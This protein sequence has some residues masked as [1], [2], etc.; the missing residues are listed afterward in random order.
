MPV[1]VIREGRQEGGLVRWPIPAWGLWRVEVGPR[2]RPFHWGQ[3]ETPGSA[4]SLEKR[5]QCYN[6]ILGKLF[7]LIVFVIQMTGK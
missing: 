7:M 2:Q 4:R 1:C 3:L 6:F 5:T